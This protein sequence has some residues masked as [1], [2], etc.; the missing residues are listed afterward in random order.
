VS[1]ETAPRTKGKK[2]MDG[3]IE[4]KRE[5]ERKNEGESPR[6]RHFSLL[7]LRRPAFFLGLK[8]TF[9]AR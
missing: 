5:R 8:P 9:L 4:I 3:W 6:F 7:F 2:E 1:N